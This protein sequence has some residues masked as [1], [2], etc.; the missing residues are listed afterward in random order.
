MNSSAFYR[1]C[2]TLCLI[3]LIGL[4]GLS[5]RLVYLHVVKA[6]DYTKK[7]ERVTVRKEVTKAN[8]GCIVDVNNQ[9]IARNIPRVRLALDKKLLHDIAPASLSLANK[10]LRDSAEWA[11]WDKKKRNSEIKKLA[12]RIRDDV[13]PAEII[14]E[15]IDHVTETFARPLGM[16]PD[17][18]RSRMR[19]DKPKRKYVVIKSDLS[20]DDAY[21]FK[22]LTR[23]HS[24]LQAFIFE[25]LQKRW[26]VMPEMASHIIGYVNHSGAG[27]AGIESKMNEFMAG[28]DGFIKSH[29][30]KFDLLAVAKPH[31]VMPPIH[32]LNVQLTLDMGIQSILEEELDAGLAEF[33]AE[34]GTIVMMDPHSGAVLGMASRPCYNL[35]TRENI[36][37]NGYDFA[38]QAIYEPGSTFKII[39]A[40]GALDKNLVQPSTKI[41][42][43]N[44][45]YHSGSVRVPDH[46]PYG[47]L[48]VEQVLAKSSNPGAY[49]LA[50]KLGNNEFFNY[51]R[52]FGFGEKTNIMMA[53]ESSG[54]V[55]NTGN[56]VDFSRVSYGYAVSVTPLQVACA[57]SVLANGGKLM[58]PQLLKS[59][60]AND[61]SVIQ[62]FTPV[63][64]RRVISE[65]T[66]KKMRRALAT[67]VDP[68]GTAK[69]AAVRGYDAAGK[70]G[71]T[72]KIN[73]K[74][75][76]LAGRYTVSFAGMMPV[77]KP[78]FVCVV[79][80]DD[81]QTNEV[82]RYG[83]TI[84]APIFSKVAT[85]VAN[86]MGVE[87]TKP[88][89]LAH[90]SQ[91]SN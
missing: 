38:T 13:A 36:A 55:N 56:A 84:A 53:G 23:D 45:L 14:D 29:R 48:T 21:K 9:L 2:L 91:Q 77:E 10:E 83:G 22:E 76:Y 26:Y 25:E 7:S 50:L 49:K 11:S 61:G 5:V 68:K 47:M 71:T 69:R 34:K 31:E 19:L 74:G 54:V 42:C 3:F 40:A 15:H 46:H 1:R 78:E 32:G 28:K 70:T 20:E 58:E 82:K 44:G 4:T 63:E 75:G 60:M 85:R 30:D 39:A 89:E 43:H 66:S 6:G 52:G 72:V 59:I 16:T 65:S 67:V 51:L 87:P 90:V 37:K 79:V 12:Q 62:E 81:P 88:V 24:V 41:F 33:K 8:R 73:P 57:Y 35:N 86:R 64:V 27:K 80:I 18:L 17:E